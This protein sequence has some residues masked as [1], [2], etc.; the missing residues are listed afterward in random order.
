MDAAAADAAVDVV[1]PRTR[2]R[3]AAAA[4]G[5]ALAGAAVD[6]ALNEPGAPG[7]RFLPCAFHR[8]TGL[9]CPGCGLTRGTHALFTGHPV[10][11]L[12]YNLFTPLALVG[13]VVAWA[14][15]A[16]RCWG[17]PVRNPFERLPERWT[18]VLL[19]AVLVFGVV[20]NLPFVPF[21]SLAP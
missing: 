15:W 7:S 16:L 18:Q 6:T 9:W 5:C 14:A 8:L 3:L 1:A 17:R 10:E 12:G 21:R 19:V 11:A 4:C 20:R 2:D 13:I